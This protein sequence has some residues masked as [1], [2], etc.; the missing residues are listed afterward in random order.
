MGD[1]SF[2]GRKAWHFSSHISVLTREKQAVA[3]FDT[4]FGCGFKQSQCGSACQDRELAWQPHIYVT[5]VA[6]LFGS[7]FYVPHSLLLQLQLLSA[8]FI[9]NL[10]KTFPQP[11]H[12]SVTRQ[13]CLT[14]PP[15]NHIAAATSAI[16]IAPS[17]ANQVL[18]SFPN[19]LEI[20]RKLQ[21][22][23]LHEI[24]CSRSA[25]DCDASQR[26][27]PAASRKTT[28]G[29]DRSC[30][31]D[32]KLSS[33]SMSTSTVPERTQTLGLPHRLNTIRYKILNT[34]LLN[35]Y[36]NQLLFFRADIKSCCRLYQPVLLRNDK[37]NNKKNN[38]IDT[39]FLQQRTRSR[40]IRPYK[41]HTQKVCMRRLIS[42]IFD[43][44]THG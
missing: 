24:D 32:I 38:S 1:V 41:S 19:T 25:L 22:C 39:R 36:A 43:I 26:L 29:K 3:P 21:R 33:S 30:L 15:S 5:S 35:L 7:C 10:P 44:D 37:N 28:K 42:G 11:A 27:L 23:V 14:H 17:H 6:L 31:S 20:N 2:T 16:T 9:F 34:T 40:F 12:H 8:E 4:N 18:P 13:S